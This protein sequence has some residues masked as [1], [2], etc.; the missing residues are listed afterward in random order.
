M[1]SPGGSQVSESQINPLPCPFPGPFPLASPASLC[2]RQMAKSI[3]PNTPTQPTSGI[4]MTK[5]PARCKDPCHQ[6]AGSQE[7]RTAS[8]HWLMPVGGRPR[9]HSHLQKQQSSDEPMECRRPLHGTAFLPK[10][11]I[12]HRNA[13]WFEKTA[14]YSLKAIT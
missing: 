3:I 7:S 11:K 5:G 10:L 1:H 4:P 14:Y 9:T 13:E 2:R 8:V 12:L 6:F